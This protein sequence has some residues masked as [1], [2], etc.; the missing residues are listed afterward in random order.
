MP[1]DG[2]RGR[3]PDARAEAYR[4]KR[5]RRATDDLELTRLFMRHASISTTSEHY[6]HADKDELIAGMRRAEERWRKS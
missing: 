5:V 6:M 3:F 4:W 1:A 2:G